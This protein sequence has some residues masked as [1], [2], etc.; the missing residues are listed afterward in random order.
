MGQKD[1]AN[2]LFDEQIQENLL[3]LKN[4][5][6]EEN[7][8]RAYDLAA[9]YAFRNQSG[10]AI[11]WLR[12]AQERGFLLIDLL[13]RDPLFDPIRENEKYKSIIS[14][15]EELEKEDEP[16][17]NLVKQKIRMLEENGILML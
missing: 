1:E 4:G 2:S 8:R 5:D 7:A 6:V 13:E 11:K 14:L 10:E 3:I 9:I 16:K 12:M 17:F 15:Q